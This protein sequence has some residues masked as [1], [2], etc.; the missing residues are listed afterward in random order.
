V[1]LQPRQIH[2]LGSREA[3]KRARIKRRR[4]ACLGWIPAFVPWRKDHPD[5]CA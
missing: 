4:V 3:C 5:P 2:I 1:K